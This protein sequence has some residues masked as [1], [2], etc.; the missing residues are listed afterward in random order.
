MADDG[1][2]K[3]PMTDGRRSETCARAKSLLGGYMETAPHSLRI[4]TMAR[5]AHSGCSESRLRTNELRNVRAR[6]S[7][8]K[9]PPDDRQPRSTRRT[10][11]D[12]R[13]THTPTSALTLNAAVLRHRGPSDGISTRVCGTIIVRTPRPRVNALTTVNSLSSDRERRWSASARVNLV[14]THCARACFI[15]GFDFFSPHPS[16]HQLF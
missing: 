9:R 6:P 16:S 12:P 1:D 10:R 8:H 11:A 4:H 2:P 13:T 15:F 3:H 5:Y 14:P 7:Q